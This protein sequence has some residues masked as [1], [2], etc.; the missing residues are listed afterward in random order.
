MSKPVTDRALAS[1]WPGSGLPNSSQ[2]RTI[3]G[4]KTAS[5]TTAGTA[6]EGDLRGDPATPG[7][8]PDDERARRSRRTPPR[9]GSARRGRSATP[10]AEQPP[11]GQP[12]RLRR[13]QQPRHQRA[14]RQGEDREQHRRVGQGRVEDERQV[15]GRGQ[16][17]ADR[18]DAGAADRQAALDRRRRRRSATRAPGTSEPTSDRHPLGGARTSSRGAPSGSPRGT[19]AAAARPR[20]PG[21]GTT[22]AASGSSR[23]RRSSG[24]GPRAGS[25]RRRRS[26][27]CPRAAGRR[28]STRRGCGRRARPRRRAATWRARSRRLIGAARAAARPSRSAG[29]RGS[30]R[31]GRRST[32]RLAAGPGIVAIGGP[33]HGGRAPSTT[34]AER[35]DRVVALDDQPLDLVGVGDRARSSRSGRSG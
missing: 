9:C 8:G 7:R 17:G 26:R 21:A 3:H 13:S 11:V 15:D 20:T 23:S 2:S 32:L 25:G 16:P 35:R 34:G 10:S 30:G 12:E 5:A 6:I 14:G 24:R 31:P 22:A 1:A 4:A 27:R 19:S 33:I 18:E 28:R 29:P